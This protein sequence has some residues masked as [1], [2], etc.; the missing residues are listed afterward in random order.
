MRMIQSKQKNVPF[1]FCAAP[2][3][4]DKR[5]EWG[6]DPSNLQ[7]APDGAFLKLKSAT[8]ISHLVQPNVDKTAPIGWVQ[9]SS[10]GLFDK[11]PI[12][13]DDEVLQPGTTKAMKTRD[14]DLN[15]DVTEPAAVCYNGNGTGPDLTDGWVQTIRE[16]EKNYDL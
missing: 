14:G 5:T 9:G 6:S 7:N 8:E 1:V 16:L 4:I 2:V 13:I 11:A 10:P 3:T 15:Y 12:W